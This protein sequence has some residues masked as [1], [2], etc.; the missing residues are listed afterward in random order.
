VMAP[1]SG[2]RDRSRRP[3]IRDVARAANVSVGTVSNAI[4]T[5]EIV[6]PATRSRIQ[7]VIEEL[8][9]RPSLAARAT[10][11]GRATFVGIA[12]ADMH[13]SLFVEISLG[14][15]D[16]MSK[17][18]DA[19]LIAN[20][21]VSVARQARNLD[22]LTSA[23]VG[24]IILTPIDGVLEG[25]EN[26][27]RH[28]G[29]VVL[30]DYHARADEACSVAVDEERAGYL[31]GMHLVASG[32]TRI[33][34]VGHTRGW[35]SVRQ[36]YDGAVRAGLERHPPVPVEL[37]SVRDLR[38]KDGYDAGVVLASRESKNRPRGVIG[39][40]DQVAAGVI[41]GLRDTAGLRVPEDILVVGFDDNHFAATTGIPVT[42]V[43]KPGVEMGRIAAQ[44]LRTEIS[45]GT[46]H[47][48]TNIL[49]Q[50]TLITRRSSV[51]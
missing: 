10:A 49:L 8:G 6:K 28:V 22:F 16:E 48:H 19:V 1:R 50:S 2:R 41:Q 39:A 18:G 31:A 37:L 27:T 38:P 40:T 5:P 25:M 34:F 3:T 21:D 24:G 33:T 45:E 23:G 14:A 11:T 46:E 36:R 32:A 4:N 35:L 44:L 26:A 47:L 17:S 42:T 30:A 7:N 43:A 9:F 12:I 13:N 29:H 15:E 51:N 20:S